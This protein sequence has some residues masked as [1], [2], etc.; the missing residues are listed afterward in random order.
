MKICI[1]E[2]QKK[3]INNKKIYGEKRN[4]SKIRKQIKFLSV[5]EKFYKKIENK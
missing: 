2:K 1:I 5:Y 3:D 4:I